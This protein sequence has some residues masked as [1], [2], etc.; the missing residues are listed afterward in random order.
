L[1]CKTSKT[2]DLFVVEL[3]EFG[4]FDEHDDGGESPHSRDRDEDCEAGCEFWLGL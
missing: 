2:G 1:R 3:A 4:H